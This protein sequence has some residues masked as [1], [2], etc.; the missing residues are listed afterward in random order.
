MIVNLSQPD[1]IRCVT[2][3]LAPLFS[4]GKH[5][6]VL[7]GGPLGRSRYHCCILLIVNLLQLS[8]VSFSRGF[9]VPSHRASKPSRL[10]CRITSSMGRNGSEVFARYSANSR[11]EHRHLSEYLRRPLRE[12]Q[13]VRQDPF[14]D[15][16][17]S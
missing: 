10:D 12:D 9:K 8:C 3:S 7:A 17:S 4:G 5:R 13:R 1:T 14:L 15:R 16:C 11:A 2:I 6:E